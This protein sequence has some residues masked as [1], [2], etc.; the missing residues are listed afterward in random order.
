MPAQPV[1]A[2]ERFKESYRSSFWVSLT[3]ATLFHAAVLAGS[4]AFAWAT[5]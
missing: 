3:I 2:N 5:P 1:T 4:P